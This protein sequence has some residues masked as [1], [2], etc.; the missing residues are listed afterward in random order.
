[1]KHCPLQTFSLTIVCCMVT[2]QLHGQL[3]GSTSFQSNNPIVNP[4]TANASIIFTEIEIGNTPV[5][6]TQIVFTTQNCTSPATD[7]TNVKL[8]Y[9]NDTTGLEID[10]GAVLIGTYYFPWNNS[11]TFLISSS[12]N[13]TGLSSFTLSGAGKHYLW[14]TYD[15]APGAIIC[16]TLDASFGS[17]IADSVQY[18][19]TVSSPPGFTVIGL[20][21]TGMQSGNHH[22]VMHLLPVP[23]TSHITGVLFSFG[24]GNLKIE[25]INMLSG[26]NYAVFDGNI[27][28]GENKFEIPVSDLPRGFYIL[29]YHLDSKT[30][31]NKVILM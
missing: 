26:T 16:D 29:R 28:H 3:L 15:V 4:N 25:L 13:Y 10:S 22:P 30:F 11:D 23:A 12:V 9:Y 7:V 17:L 8:W 19:P 24:N 5:T 21:I 6:L 18:L 20:C 1:M 2:I 31:S 14:L 27:M